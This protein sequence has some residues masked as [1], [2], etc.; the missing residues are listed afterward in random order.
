V[1]FTCKVIEFDGTHLT[2]EWIT[3]QTVP[4]FKYSKRD[5]SIKIAGE[6]QTLS[7]SEAQR[8]WKWAVKYPDYRYP[9]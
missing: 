9:D 7:R 1:L 6:R 8:F 4:H 5:Q 2:V 3:P